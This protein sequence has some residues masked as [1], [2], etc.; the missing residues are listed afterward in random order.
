MKILLSVKPE[1]IDKIFDGSKTFEYRR[2]L[3]QKTIS[4]IV[5][6][7]TDPVQRIVG[8]VEVIGTISASPTALWEQTKHNAGISRAKY[9]DYF[10]KCKNAN[11]FVLGEVTKYQSPKAL[12]DYDINSAP[13]SFQYL[14][15]AENGS[16]P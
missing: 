14:V 12:S 8:E 15:S 5:L 3:P 6:Y 16:T 11:A 7:A 4:S 2:K 1:Y 9:R 10:H 13:Q